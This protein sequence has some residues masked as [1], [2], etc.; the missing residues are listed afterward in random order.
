[1][2]VRRV[3]LS[4]VFLSSL[5]VLSGCLD[6]EADPVAPDNVPPADTTAPVVVSVRPA[7]EVTGV[8]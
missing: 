1:M 4:V 7:P 2:F 6:R 3:A 5:L 8:P